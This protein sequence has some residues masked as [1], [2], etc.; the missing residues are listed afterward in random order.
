MKITTKLGYGV[1]K[2][3]GFIRSP[4]SYFRADFQADGL[5][6]AGK[7]LAFLD[8]PAFKSA[9]AFSHELNQEGWQGKVP[10]IRWR[11]H[12][13]CW[14]A[15]HCLSIPGDFA[16]FGVHTGITSLTVCKLHD[17]GS[18][19]KYYHLFDTFN[20]IPTK[21]A[22]SDAERKLVAD[23]NAKLY[24]DCYAIAERN[25][26][27]FPNVR[28]IR[29]ILPQSLEPRP[30]SKLAFVHIDLNN[31]VAELEV[32]SAIWDDISFGGIILLDDYNFKGYEAQHDGWNAFCAARGHKVLS[33]PTGQ[34]LIIRH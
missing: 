34:G 29:G 12:V 28:L 25:F 5:A 33:L 13:A 22:M 10:D 24:F 7:N 21:D 8:D 2:A 31:S 23:I 16:E 20:G 26:S 27:D 14:A 17:F 30:F 15:G 3:V 19:P 1:R 32:I 4:R 11:A 9:W 6:V 18:I